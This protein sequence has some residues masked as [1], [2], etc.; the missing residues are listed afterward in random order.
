[1]HCSKSQPEGRHSIGVSDWIPTSIRHEYFL[2]E[3]QERMIFCITCKTDLVC[4]HIVWSILAI[5]GYDYY[6]NFSHNTWWS[7]CLRIKHDIKQ[8]CDVCNGGDLFKFPQVMSINTKYYSSIAGY[9]VRCCYKYTNIMIS[10]T[11][12]RWQQQNINQIFNWQNTSHSSPSRASYKVSVVFCIT[13]K[14][15]IYK[16]HLSR[17]YNC[18]SLR[19]SWSIA[20]RRCSYYIFMLRLTLQAAIDCAKTT[21]RWDEKYLGFV[22]LVHLIL[23][24]RWYFLL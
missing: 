14:S 3:N 11:A 15:L 21:A 7:W 8:L 17:Q 4:W 24:I 12:L 23:E 10:H 18:W 20:C 6:C 2:N 1:M 9:T 16:M 5:A 22:D 19:C 13:V